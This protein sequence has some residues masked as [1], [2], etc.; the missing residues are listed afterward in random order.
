MKYIAILIFVMGFFGLMDTAAQPDGTPD[1]SFNQ[2]SYYISGNGNY[3]GMAVGVQSNGMVIVAGQGFMVDRSFVARHTANGALDA[4]F[5]S[6]GGMQ[7]FNFYSNTTTVMDMAVLPNDQIVVAGRQ[8]IPNNSLGLCARFTSAGL[9][10]PTFGNSGFVTF[11][12]YGWLWNFNR[13]IAQPDG[14]L[15]LCGTGD[16]V[17]AV[18]LRLQ[19]NGSPDSS[20]GSN[21]FVFFTPFD[22]LSRVEL[23]DI[24]LQPD[25]KILT[26]GKRYTSDGG[27]GSYSK[28]V[29]FR[30][31]TDGSP[32]NTFG[33]GGEALY[34]VARPRFNYVYRIHLMDDGRMVL[35]GTLQDEYCSEFL[36]LRLQPNGQLD[37]TYG[38]GGM[39]RF[40]YIDTTVSLSCIASLLQPDG[41]VIMTTPVSFPSDSTFSTL[42]RLQSDGRID[43]SFGPSHNGF[44]VHHMTRE[45]T[46]FPGNACWDNDGNILLC[47]MS[48]T[49]TSAGCG[50]PYYNVSRYLNAGT[51]TGI[52]SVTDET[53]PMIFPVP[54]DQRLTISSDKPAQVEVYDAQGRRV[55]S[56]ETSGDS[57]WDVSSW[58]CGIYLIRCGDSVRRVIK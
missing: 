54:F 53:S 4:T 31:N 34:H 12:P 28:S 49:C 1:P 40:D 6:M 30:L 45:N 48:R 14:K 24:A 44:L 43:T 36:A 5:G 15:L 41:K 39:V 23:F 46:H 26:T 29:T 11:M 58:P 8:S 21:G 22:S 20:F 2:Q 50:S 56:G 38:S 47:G 19:P 25:G 57:V 10:D 16:I 37:P 3:Y 55:I 9:L 27:V 35:T 42:V 51:A 18:L 7:L 17:D 33:V 32:D 52:P 13:V